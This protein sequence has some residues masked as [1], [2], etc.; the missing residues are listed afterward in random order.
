MLHC[1][2]DEG[3]YTVRLGGLANG[4]AYVVSVSCKTTAG[5]S[6]SCSSVHDICSIVTPF[7]P[8]ALFAPMPLSAVLLVGLVIVLSPV[9]L[10]LFNYKYESPF[11]DERCKCR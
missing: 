6:S 8:P 10:L 4:V 1:A 2:D 3:M 9:T 11:S 5:S 7:G